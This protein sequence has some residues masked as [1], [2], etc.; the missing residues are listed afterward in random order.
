MYGLSDGIIGTE[1][2]KANKVVIMVQPNDD[3]QIEL[4]VQADGRTRAPRKAIMKEGG[5]IRFRTVPPKA[6]PDS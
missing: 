6:R 4:I 5:R 3:S 2:A 1:L